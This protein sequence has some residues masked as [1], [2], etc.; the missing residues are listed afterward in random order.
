MSDPT[1]KPHMALL[2]ALDAKNSL[3]NCYGFTPFQL[4]L[5][6]T[7][8]MFTATRDNPPSLERNAKSENFI[9]HLNALHA[10]RSWP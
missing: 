3:E 4:H 2:W 5:G 9:A 10:A 8:M 1:L 7:P 6:R